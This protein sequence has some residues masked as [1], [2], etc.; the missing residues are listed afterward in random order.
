MKARK[1][2]S[3]QGQ[4]SPPSQRRLRGG[5]GGVSAM[6]L[7]ACGC[8]PCDPGAGIVAVAQRS[9]SRPLKCGE[10]LSGATPGGR[11]P[12]VRWGF[13]RGGSTGGSKEAPQCRKLPG[14]IG[15]RISIPPSRLCWSH[16]HIPPMVSWKVKLGAL[17]GSE[18]PGL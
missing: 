6:H 15:E 9:Y 14:Q 10:K 3:P 11:P 17:R 7:A 2:R 12:A 5:G 8:S 16:T 13:L 4:W 1:A 18:V